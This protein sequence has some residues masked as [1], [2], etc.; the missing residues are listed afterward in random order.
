MES[1]C[2]PEGPQA[3]ETRC[4]WSDLDLREHIPASSH[5][6]QRRSQPGNQPGAESRRVKFCMVLFKGKSHLDESETENQ[7]EK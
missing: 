7:R 5:A 6:A 1:L 3:P 4:G 2:S